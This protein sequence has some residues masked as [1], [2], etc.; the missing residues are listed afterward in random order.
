[1]NV[2]GTI[3]KLSLQENE[4]IALPEKIEKPRS[5]LVLYIPLFTAFITL[6]LVALAI[7]NGWLGPAAQVGVDFGEASHPGLIKQPANTYSSLG[8]VFSGLL[9]GWSLMRG[10]GR[11]DDNPFMR[12]TF[13]STLFASL[14]VCLGP[15]SIAMHA[16]ES[17]LGGH[18]DLLS[19]YLVAAYLIAYSVKRFFRLRPV[20]FLFLFATVVI[21]CVSVQDLRFSTPLVGDFGEFI[22]GFFIITAI[23][24]EMFNILIRNANHDVKWGLFYV[25]A[26]LVAFLIWNLSLSDTPS[27]SLIQGHAIWHLLCAASAYCLF[28]FYA[29][30]QPCKASAPVAE[31]VKS[32]LEERALDVLSRAKGL[33]Q[34][35]ERA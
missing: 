13:F 10:T 26:L 9:I 29:S 31:N 17:Q 25:G 28:R 6:S 20:W 2:Q 12:S 32:G 18:L 35:A 8:F 19:M 3:Q 14:V 1:M 34:A 21:L 22:F 30:E 27:H 5:R 24:F 7:S 23:L 11:Q 16:T 4:T 15:G 33:K